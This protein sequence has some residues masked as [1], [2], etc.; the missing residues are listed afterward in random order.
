MNR[1]QLPLLLK[2]PLH[3]FKV[4]LRHEDVYLVCSR[5]ND[6]RPIGV[7]GVDR[8]KLLWN[9]RN[10]THAFIIPRARKA[11]YVLF[12]PSCCRGHEGCV[13]SPHL[14]LRESRGQ[15]PHHGRLV[16]RKRQALCLNRLVGGDDPPAEVEF[17]PHGR[18]AVVDVR[19]EGIDV[20][21]RILLKQER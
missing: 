5:I 1:T 10:G 13:D 14:V 12:T 6:T 16:G 15:K 8:G 21:R 11:C 4:G 17:R 7:A 3:G 18:D 19:P 20:F 2:Q 9:E